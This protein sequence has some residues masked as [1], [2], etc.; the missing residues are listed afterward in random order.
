MEETVRN[1][2]VAKDTPKA[3]VIGLKKEMPK[4]LTSYLHTYNPDSGNFESKAGTTGGTSS[5]GS[6]EM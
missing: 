2:C 4:S 3:Y 6:A 5:V 1:N